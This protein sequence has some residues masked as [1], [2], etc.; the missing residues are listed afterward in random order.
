MHAPIELPSQPGN[1]ELEMMVV[2]AL[3]VN[4]GASGGASLRLPVRIE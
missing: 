4:S 2:Q 1:Y 3:S